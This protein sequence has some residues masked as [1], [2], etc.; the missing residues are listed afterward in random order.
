LKTKYQAR[1]RCLL[2]IRG[3]VLTTALT[4]TFE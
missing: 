2:Y 4:E 1:L 3:R